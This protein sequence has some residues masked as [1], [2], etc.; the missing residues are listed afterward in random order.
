MLRDDG[1]RL[2]MPPARVFLAKLLG[3]LLVLLALPFLLGA[4]DHAAKEQVLFRE[5]VLEIVSP[6]SLSIDQCR[7]VAK[8]AL[9]AWKFDL[10]QM[11]WAHPAEVERPLTLRLVSAERLKKEHPG[12]RAMA[13]W[14]GNLFTMRTNLVDD[15]TG[16][17][18]I[19]HELGH[20]QAFRVLGQRKH[21]VPLYFIEGHGL[22]MN[23]LYADHLRIPDSGGW[24]NNLRTIMSLSA[25]EARII[26]TDDSYYNN[27]KDP[28]KTFKMECMGV[29]FVEYMRVRY[30]GKGIQDMVPRMGRVF[31]RVGRG[32]TYEQAFEQTYGISVNQAVSEVVASFERTEAH[33]AERLKGTRFEALLSANEAGKSRK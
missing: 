3:F 13:S 20:I 17:L 29:Y 1:Q 24:V 4:E 6:D 28:K 33:P 26:L 21:S 19:A 18:T 32:E 23:R 14:N 2:H 27:E 25:K 11:R 7:R 15:P 5:G 31:E 12:L 22:I 9:A 10:N 16:N 30:H 8:M